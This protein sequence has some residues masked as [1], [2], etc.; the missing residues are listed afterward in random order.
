MTS[1]ILLSD[2][3]EQ[4]GP[5]KVVPLSVGE[6]VS[7][8]PSSFVDGGTDLAKTYIPAGT[9]A[10][11]EVSV[12]GPAG[13]LFSYRSEVLH[14]GSRTTGETLSKIHDVCSLRRVGT[15]LDRPNRL[16]R[17]CTRP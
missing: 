14:R 17:P 15:T 6:R 11:E 12:L 10:Q 16:A 7:Y 9:F 4:D 1:L 2:V 13:T 3:A 8:W 5:T